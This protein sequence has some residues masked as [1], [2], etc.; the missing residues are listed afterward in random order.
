MIL[1]VS[2][3]YSKRPCTA[4]RSRLLVRALLLRRDPP[5]RRRSR[6]IFAHLLPMFVKSAAIP[7]GV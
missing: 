3:G 2:P 4:Y 5:R 1:P 6:G 7:G